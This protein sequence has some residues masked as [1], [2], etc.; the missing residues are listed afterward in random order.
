MKRVIKVSVF[1]LCVVAL[2]ATSKIVGKAN[3]EAVK[4]KENSNVTNEDS[5]TTIEDSKDE[6]EEFTYRLYVDKWD[7]YSYSKGHNGKHTIEYSVNGGEVVTAEMKLDVVGWLQTQPL[8]VSHCI[9]VDNVKEGD[10]IDYK[11]SYYNTYLF[12]DDTEPAVVSGSKVV[13][14]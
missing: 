7:M 13:T 4:E 14:R 6:S 10:V 12:P 8:Y 5:G 11:Y 9:D 3:G 1:L 2:L